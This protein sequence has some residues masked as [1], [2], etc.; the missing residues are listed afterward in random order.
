MV[1]DEL[2]GL[3]KQL[4]KLQAQSP[5]LPPTDDDMDQAARDSE[6]EHTMRGLK[7]LSKTE[8]IKGPD[9]QELN[10]GN[11]EMDEGEVEAMPS[12]LLPVGL[13]EVTPNKDDTQH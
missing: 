13:K 9:M 5:V 4:E 11:E 7:A 12:V 2:T 6:G 8:T 1:H 3:S 10:D